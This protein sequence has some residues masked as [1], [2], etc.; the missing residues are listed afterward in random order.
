MSVP[1]GTIVPYLGDSTTVPSGWLLCNGAVISR[2]TYAALFAAVNTAYGA[3]DGSTTFRLPGQASYIY[4]SGAGTGTASH[5]SQHSVVTNVNAALQASAVNHTHGTNTPAGASGNAFPDTN[6]L[7]T[8][9]GGSTNTGANTAY[10]ATL[11]GSTNYL[12]VDTHGH[13]LGISWNHADHSHSVN[14]PSIGNE[15]GHT[16]TISLTPT[17]M[18]SVSSA[19]TVLPNTAIWHLIKC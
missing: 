3:G 8:H 16:H 12:E 4:A 11:G 9:S 19:S 7:G 15:I 2:T 10:G 14:A 13:P 5:S 6:Y 18:G 17:S 1:V